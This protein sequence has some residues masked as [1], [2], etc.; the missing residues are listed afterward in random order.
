[1]AHTTIR[2]AL[3]WAVVDAATTALTAVIGLLVLSR[4][5]DPRDFGVVAL[6]QSIV[7][8]AQMFTS[9]GIREAVIRH[10][11]VDV[12]YRDSA[13]WL[14][15]SLGLLGFLVCCGIAA[16]FALFGDEAILGPVLAASAITL[17][18]AGFSIV[19]EALLARKLRTAALARRTMLAKAVYTAVACGLAIAGWGLW[20]IVT[21]TILQ[22]VVSTITLWVAQPRLPKLRLKLAHVRD[23][24]GYGWAVSLESALWSLTA[25][26]FVMLVG[27]V[28]GVQTLGYVNLAM[29]STE[30]FSSLLSAV[31]SRFALPMFAKAQH[32]LDQ[33]RMIHRRATE[34]LN[35]VSAPVFVGLCLTAHDWVPLFLGVKWLPA[36]PLIEAF[37]LAWAIV[38][39]RMLA[40]DCV[41]V[42]GHPRALL[43]QAV[44]AGMATAVGVLLTRGQ[45]MVIVAYV[46]VIART[47]ITAPMSIGLL[48]K[49]AGLGYLDQARPLI[50]PFVAAALMAG[51]VL[52]GRLALPTPLDPEGSLPRLALDVGLGVMAY[53]AACG[54]L[55]RGEIKALRMRISPA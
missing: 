47:L 10:R 45:E 38:F 46:W 42:T 25:R 5:L 52:G 6:A 44:V 23:L 37:S 28:H 48:K 7:A 32:S 1:M 30:V 14:A 16:A 22:V 55:Y 18:F 11:P 12:A 34:L 54:L 15:V 17:V 53:A 8:T 2:K 36:V 13:H 27:F 21:A 39:T 19:P 29:R 33:V 20:S 49:Y 50:R 31:N 9:G 3:P 43:P 24:L 41:R 26:A 35:L 40:G 51:A 4:L